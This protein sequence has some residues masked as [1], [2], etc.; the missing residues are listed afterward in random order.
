[1]WISN[2]TIKLAALCRAVSDVGLSPGLSM[3]LSLGAFIR[4]ND[5]GLLFRRARDLLLFFDPGGKK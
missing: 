1:M 3:G 4:I 2:S 5:P